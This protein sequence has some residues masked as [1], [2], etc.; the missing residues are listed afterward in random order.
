MIRVWGCKG[1]GD[2]NEYWRLGR[3][4]ESQEALEQEFHAHGVEN[5]DICPNLRKHPTT[6]ES[7]LDVEVFIAPGEGLD[8]KQIRWSPKSSSATPGCGLD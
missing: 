7:L 1:K 4:L 2:W 3:L 8:H 5:V 6:P